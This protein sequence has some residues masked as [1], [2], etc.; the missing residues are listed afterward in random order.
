MSEPEPSLELLRIRERL[1]K[2]GR[3]FDDEERTDSGAGLRRVNQNGTW[4]CMDIQRE[5]I[6]LRW[7][8]DGAGLC[9]EYWARTEQCLRCKQFRCMECGSTW[10][11]YGARKVETID[12]RGLT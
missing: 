11:S 3:R 2:A 7:P 12:T 9:C 10:S 6:Y 8:V 1:R 4:T 5:C